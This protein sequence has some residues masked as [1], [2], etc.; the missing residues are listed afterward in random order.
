[1]A[2]C[3]RPAVSAKRENAFAKIDLALVQL[4]LCLPDAGDLR[5]RI[6][7]IRYGVV[8]DVPVTR[9]ELFHTGDPFLLRLMS[10]HWTADHVADSKNARS[11]GLEAVINLNA[12]SLVHFDTEPID[13]EPFGIGESPDGDE[14]PV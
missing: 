4:F 1:M 9:G 8:I 13:A 10:K 7:D 5:F 11:R 12:A 3:V 14:D 2:K 6:D